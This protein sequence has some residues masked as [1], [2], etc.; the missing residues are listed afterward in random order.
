MIICI[1]ILHTVH[2]FYFFVSRCSKVHP[3]SKSITYAGDCKRDVPPFS[4][5]SPGTAYNAMPLWSRTRGYVWKLIWS[6][7]SK[8]AWDAVSIGNSLQ[9]KLCLKYLRCWGFKSSASWQRQ[10]VTMKHCWSHLV[11]GDWNM[12]CFSIYWDIGNFIILTDFFLF[13]RGV[14]QPPTRHCKSCY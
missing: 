10:L 13:L 11:G 7:I 2:P 5:P 3:S 14:G 8:C 4:I 9:P 6:R 1:H 12:F